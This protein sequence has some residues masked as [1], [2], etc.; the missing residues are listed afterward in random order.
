M[1]DC[2]NCGRRF[3]NTNQDHSCL[4]TDLESHFVNKQ[5]QVIDTFVKIKNEVIKLKGVR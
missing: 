2:P 3:R 4:I 1:W 5:R